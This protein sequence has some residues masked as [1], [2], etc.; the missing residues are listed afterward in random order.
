M[1]R[2]LTNGWVPTTH[3][4]TPT[5][6]TSS[7]WLPP[8]TLPLFMV[9][10]QSLMSSSCEGMVERKK[11]TSAQESLPT[12]VL[13]QGKGLQGEGQGFGIRSSW[14]D[15]LTLSILAD[16]YLFGKQRHY[17]QPLSGFRKHMHGLWSKLDLSSNP[18]SSTCW[19]FDLGQV[20]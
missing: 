18:R 1:Q 12:V 7:G 17:I 8:N 5:Q 16:L 11:P 20:T 13:R 4:P 19:L 14:L 3:P 15:K 10:P 2:R 9:L 6:F